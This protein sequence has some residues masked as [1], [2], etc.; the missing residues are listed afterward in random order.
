MKKRASGGHKLRAFAA[1]IVG[2]TAIG[3]CSRNDEFSGIT[4]ERTAEIGQGL[5]TSGD[6]SVGVPNG[7]P[8]ASVVLGATNTLLVD[9][10]AVATETAGGFGEVTNT[11]TATTRLGVQAHVGSIVSDAPVTLSNNA[12][13]AGA[14][15][16][17]GA[18]VTQPTASNGVH[19]GSISTAATLTPVDTSATLTIDLPPVSTTNESVAGGQKLAL[20]PGNYGALQVQPG[21]TLSLTAGTYIVNSFDFE[22]SATINADATAGAITL[23]VR[24]DSFI[25]R[26]AFNLVGASSPSD[27]ILGFAGD[28][29]HLE[30]PFSGIFIGPNASVT[31][32]TTNSGQSPHRGSI[33]AS[34]IEAYSGASIVHYPLRQLIRNVTLDKSQICAGGDT[35]HVNVAAADPTNPSNPTLVTINGKPG[36][37]QY[38]QI[39]VP[40]PGTYFVEVVAFSAGH[41]DH[42]E[43]PLTVVAC[44]AST[45]T[46]IIQA[47]ASLY[48]RGL[49][50]LLV[51]NASSYSNATYSWS[52]GDGNSVTTAF[53]FVTHDYTVSLPRDGE[54]QDFDVT[55]TVTPS[56][57]NGAS[58]TKTLAIFNLYGIT[59][60]LGRLHPPA[61][62]SGT[63]LTLTG[64]TTLTGSVAVQ[65]LEDVPLSLTSQTLEY[66]PCD[67]TL[68]P[69]VGS[70]GPVSIS[71]APHT[72]STQAIAL[73]FSSLPSTVCSIGYHLSGTAGSLPAY[74]DAYFDARRNPTLSLPV[75]DTATLSLLNSVTAQGLTSSSDHVTEE[76]LYDLFAQGQISSLPAVEPDGPLFLDPTADPCAPGATPAQN[77]G[78]ACCPG[79]P[80]PTG[81]ACQAQNTW[82]A[83]P[84][85]VANALKGDIILNPGCGSSLIDTLLNALQPPQK[86]SHEGLMTLNYFQL[87]QTTSSSDRYQDYPKNSGDTDVRNGIR[88]DVLQ[89]GFQGSDGKDFTTLA[90]IPRS[91]DEAFNG[92]SLVDPESKKVYTFNSFSFKPTGCADGTQV[93]PLV[94]RPPPGAPSNVRTLLQQAADASQTIRAHYRLF[95]YSQGNISQKSS[96]NAP[97]TTASTWAIGSQAAVSSTFIWT[98]LKSV[99]GLTLGVNPLVQTQTAP[100]GEKY[101][102]PDPNQDGLFLYPAAERTTVGWAVAN[103]LYDQVY[104]KAGG[105]GEFFTVAAGHVSRQITNCFT[106][107]DCNNTGDRDWLNPGDGSTV[108]PD[109]FLEWAAPENGGVYG[110]NE[111][112]AYMG[113]GED[114]D[115]ILA[116]SAGT[117]TVTGTVTDENNNPVAQAVVTISSV[118]RDTTTDANGNYTLEGIPAGSYGINGQFV[119]GNTGIAP[120]QDCAVSGVQL[121][122][123]KQPDDIV[124]VPADGTV[125]ENLVLVGDALNRTILVSQSPT[126]PL[127]VTHFAAVTGNP[128]IQTPALDAFSCSVSPLKTQDT[129]TFG[130]C[131]D[132]G[133][134]FFQINMV[135]NL[136]PNS[137]DVEVF[138]EPQILRDCGDK[139]QV[140]NEFEQTFTPTISAGQT[141]DEFISLQYPVNFHITT[142]GGTA[143][144]DLLLLNTPT[145]SF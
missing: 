130:E 145:F 40:V 141:V 22:S 32:A 78:D 69:F 119:C 57:A 9:D 66:Q 50:E 36:P 67:P 28:T 43:V 142:S 75:T 98:A 83:T 34:T 52:F 121:L 96:F 10:R 3:A 94:V 25:Y 113:S 30:S 26:G 44:T 1:F 117:G 31:L 107:D 11:G 135:C 12:T 90:E 29:A 102:Q 7:A 63:T 116:P 108:S 91:V 47:G 112:L 140:D 100:G 19:V 92:F 37:T 93:D 125:I 101:S 64:G 84:P 62:P 110:Y 16:T 99:P 55:V 53:P 127:Q 58:A 38:T 77:P 14:V 82:H 8:A 13:V 73:A 104:Q 103:Y 123:T 68:D 17:A 138:F 137:T 59:K 76:E 115:Y 120:P 126:S 6:L 139:Q 18:S 71:V 97:S 20:A 124:N 129:E 85:R 39:N 35:V 56:G 74:V 109:N 88:T 23:Y 24:T 89:Y 79:N 134:T 42:R 122:H 106:A 4:G 111:R 128:Q 114:R 45:P 136:A 105:L 61:T 131:V 15:E 41:W 87:R 60:A 81:L 70:S 80:T 132:D 54:Y 95:G 5:S 2:I 46:P 21:G 33:F 143:S 48:H 27:V 86:Y 133:G 51:K 65:N 49:T 118:G 144:G 72:S